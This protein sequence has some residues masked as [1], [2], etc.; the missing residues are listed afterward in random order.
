MMKKGS[1][2]LFVLMATIFYLNSTRSFA[3]D[4]KSD[5]QAFDLGTVLV[6]AKNEKVDL[7][8]TVTTVT[9]EDMEAQGAQS[10]ADALFFAPGIDISHNPK[11][12]TKFSLRGFGDDAVKVLIDGVIVHEVYM[13]G[14]SLDQFPVDSIA[15]IVVTK[16]A[17][18]VLYGPNT[19]G[20]VINII[21]KKGGK[22]PFTQ[23]TTSFGE[24]A[25]QNYIFN[26]GASVDKFNYWLTYSFRT[27][28]GWELSDDFDEN[29]P[30]TGLGSDYNEDGGTR[31]L[32]DYTKRTLNA[33][34][35][36]DVDAN[37]RISLSFDYHNNEKGCPTSK[38]RYWAFAEY[39]QWHVNLVGEHDFND[40][41][42]VKARLYYMDHEDMLKD[43]GGWDANHITGK[44]WF[45]L[46]SY[47]DYSVGGELQ[48]YLNL[49]E[50]NLLKMGFNY[51]KDNNKQNEYWDQETI[52]WV[53]RKKPANQRPPAAWQPEE[54]YEAD[55]YSIG[56]ED[57]FNATDRLSIVIGASYDWWDPQKAHD[58]NP[59]DSTKG[60]NPQI[61]IV[62]DATDSLSLHASV[63]RKT[64][65][66]QLNELYSEH[67]G[68]NP[69]L[70]PKT[71]T[72]YEI[73]AKKAFSGAIN[74]S[75]AI[76]YNDIKDDI[77]QIEVDDPLSAD[78]ADTVD[79]YT[80]I[81]ESEIKGLELT[82]DARTPC[83]IYAGLNYTY[84]LS[85][86]KM[87]N[88]APT[89]DAEGIAKQKVNLDL[90]YAFDFGLS[91]FL[92]ASYTDG[93]LEYD[94]NGN[95]TKLDDYYVFNARISQEIRKMKGLE[96]KFFAE[97]K[98]IFDEDY[99]RGDGPE[100]GRSFL[101]GLSLTY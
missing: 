79:I 76:F 99:Y 3:A 100:P 36:Y 77:D 83:G 75:V 7:S 47:D 82:L 21:T 58:V 28:D 23:F 59:P 20:G 53:F 9:T 14:M 89:I 31:D 101:A 94:R 51:I 84:L 11:G 81:G 10:V 25:T 46:S 87:D 95:K 78:P 16:G 85:E 50:R 1:M 43:V 97:L 22:E 52:D 56:I 69:D 35:G 63:S 73:G 55:T 88:N 5:P 74:G 32:S 39:D 30:E 93:I 42:M 15:K 40:S 49:G 17:S 6:T 67:A 38:S 27:S 54:E 98:N 57:E 68:G 96:C 45:E 26:H 33:K 4:E 65:F 70:D 64:R 72:L 60:F 44:K 19:L 80:N 62:Y 92:Q 66:P 61:G 29:D 2:L 48:A 41:L 24:N 37:S 86:E 8:T 34:I 90:R 18:S 12:D 71:N 13:N 91:V